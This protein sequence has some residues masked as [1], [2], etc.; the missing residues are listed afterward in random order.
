MEVFYVRPADDDP[1]VDGLFLLHDELQFYLRSE[2]A[3]ADC[4]RRNAQE[5]AS[6][7][8]SRQ[9]SLAQW[10]KVEVA[11]QSLV[12]LGL[13][14]SEVF[15]Y[16]KRAFGSKTFKPYYVVDSIQVEE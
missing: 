8:E 11:Y 3:E 2:Q 7:D 15:P 12:D 14:P 13:E 1:T 4:E 5:R 6:W 9:R 10:E 16:H